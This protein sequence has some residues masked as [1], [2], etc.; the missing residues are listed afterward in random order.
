MKFC[1]PVHFLYLVMYRTYERKVDL[2]IPE[3]PRS[4]IGI[5][6][7]GSMFTRSLADKFL[8]DSSLL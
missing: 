3:S 1:V 4:R 6:V 8:N 2:P 7:D 5:S